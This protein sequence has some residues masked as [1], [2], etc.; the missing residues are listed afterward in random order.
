MKKRVIK[1]YTGMTLI[2]FK[3]LNAILKSTYARSHT[4]THTA[5]ERKRIKI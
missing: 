5:G 2:V 4:Y 3:K 1:Q